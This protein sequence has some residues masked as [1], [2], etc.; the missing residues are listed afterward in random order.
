MDS[1]EKQ[2]LREQMF[3]GIFH[4]LG[5]HFKVTTCKER[6]KLFTFPSRSAIIKFVKTKKE[7]SWERR[8]FMTASKPHWTSIS[9]VKCCSRRPATAH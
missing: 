7:M 8:G 9:E 1:K 4:F 6:K 2:C 5:K 3:L